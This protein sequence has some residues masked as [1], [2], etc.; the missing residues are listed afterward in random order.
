MDYTQF[1]KLFI[2]WNNDT[3][4][5]SSILGKSRH[6]HSEEIFR[7][8]K[9]SEHNRNLIL[10]YAFLNVENN[11][12]GLI[13]LHELLVKKPEIP[14]EVR[15]IMRTIWKIYKDWGTSNSFIERCK[16]DNIQFIRSCFDENAKEKEF[17]KLTFEWC[18]KYPNAKIKYNSIVW[19]GIGVFLHDYYRNFPVA[20]IEDCILILRPRIDM[21]PEEEKIWRSLR[22]EYNDLTK[23]MKY[24]SKESYDYL[25]SINIDVDDC[26]DKN[27]AKREYNR[28]LT[29]I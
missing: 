22:R 1:K 2:E 23:T 16:L 25:R 14:D 3:A 26:F 11:H 28:N 8:A 7:F 27:I 6:H 19:N 29:Y 17:G 20:E 4:A 15:G 24:D 10:S 5:M 9:E 13:I 12:I 18:Y 21:T